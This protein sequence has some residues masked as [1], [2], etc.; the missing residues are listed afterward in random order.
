MNFNSP[1]P[2]KAVCTSIC[3]NTLSGIAYLQT[4]MLVDQPKRVTKLG[5]NTLSGIAY[6]QTNNRIGVLIASTDR[7]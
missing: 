6:L 7:S 1:V 3:L 2:V 4:L 5:L